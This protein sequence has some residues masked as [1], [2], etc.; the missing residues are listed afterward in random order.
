MWKLS[1]YLKEQ[2]LQLLVHHE[3]TYLL[4]QLILL[5]LEFESK[6]NNAHKYADKIPSDPNFKFQD[7]PATSDAKIHIS[8]MNRCNVQFYQ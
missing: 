2:K 6:Q 8:E 4:I 1:F 3:E 7:R 5:F